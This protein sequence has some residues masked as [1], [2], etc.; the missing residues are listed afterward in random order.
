MGLNILLELT[1]LKTNV[2]LVNTRQMKRLVNSSKFL[3]LM[4]VKKKEKDVSDAF[5][6]CNPSHKQELVKIISNCDEQFQEPTGLSPKRRVEHE[7]Y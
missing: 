3:V 7:I 4:M 6:G 1:I 5:S 2:S